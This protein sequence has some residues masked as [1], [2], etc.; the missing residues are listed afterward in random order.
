MLETAKTNSPGN[1]APMLEEVI[2]TKWEYKFV[3]SDEAIPES[4]SPRPHKN[5]E[6]WTTKFLNE[7]G[8]EGWE[9][10]DW[11]HRYIQPDEWHSVFKRE[12][13]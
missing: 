9:L 13:E 6:E 8:Q 4:G 5:W 2:M 1:P 12:I 7:L 10:V 3:N 11:Q